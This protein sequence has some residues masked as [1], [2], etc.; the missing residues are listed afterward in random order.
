MRHIFYGKERQ[1]D[2]QDV[3]TYPMFSNNILVRFLMP[4][5]V[6]STTVQ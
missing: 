6:H 1:I 2:R 5:T 3:G 4:D